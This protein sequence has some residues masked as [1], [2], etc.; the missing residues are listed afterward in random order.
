MQAKPSKTSLL[1]AA[2]GV[3]VLALGAVF[4]LT[5]S[6]APELEMTEAIPVGHEPIGL[7]RSG[8]GSSLFV[9]NAADGSLTTITLANR[10]TQTQKIASQRL[11]SVALAPDGKTLYVTEVE[12]GRVYKLKLNQ[13]RTGAQVVGFAKTGEFPQGVIVSNDSKTIYTADTGS[14]TVS[15]IDSATLT[16]RTSIGVGERPYSLEFGGQHNIYVSTNVHT[17]EVIDPISEKPL[18]TLDFG[19]LTRLQGLAVSSEGKVFVAD[20]LTDLVQ[21]IDP[22]GKSRLD[23]GNIPQD[24]EFSPT[25]VTLSP[26]G[27]RLYVIGRSGYLGVINPRSSKTI[28]TLKLGGDLRQVVTG[29][30]GWVYATDFSGNRVVV[31]KPI[32]R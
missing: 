8:D 11:N 2:A 6:P 19:E 28:Q 29:A 12:Q 15:V 24:E 7:V 32:N 26:D 3:L 16:R 14:N 21:V 10:S 20:G 23:P 25:D 5:R 13:A 17:I 27:S 1:L 30:D 22:S 9:V 4:V 31:A 18:T